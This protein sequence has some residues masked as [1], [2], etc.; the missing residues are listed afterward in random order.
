MADDVYE[1]LSL[2]PDIGMPNVLAQEVEQAQLTI[3]ANN[4]EQK[5]SYHK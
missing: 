3:P 2:L 1:A 4:D 5:L